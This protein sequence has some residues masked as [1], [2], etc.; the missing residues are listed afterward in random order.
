[1]YSAFWRYIP[2]IVLYIAVFFIVALSVKLTLN[3]YC[4]Q[5]FVVIKCLLLS[6]VYCYQMFNVIRCLLFFNLY[7]YTELKLYF[8]ASSRD[9]I[10]KA[11]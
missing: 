6:T 1:M 3:V 7:I 9:D 8:S 5:V 10:R 2:V 4:Y 11:Y